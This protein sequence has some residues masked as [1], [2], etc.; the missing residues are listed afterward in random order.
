MFTKSFNPLA[1]LVSPFFFAL[2]VISLGIP[3]ATAQSPVIIFTNSFDS[4]TGTTP[5][6]F[7][8][9]AAN[10]SHTYVSGEGVGGSVGVRISGDFKPPGNGYGGVAYQYQNGA[11]TGNTNTD[12]HNYT[13]SFDAKPSRT[14]GGLQIVLQTWSGNGYGGIG[15]LTSSSL[16]DVILGDSNVF[17]HCS[18]NLGV[19]LGA[20]A[21][22]TAHTWQ[23]AFVMDEAPFGGPGTGDQLVI[24]NVSVTMGGPTWN[25]TNSLNTARVYQNNA[26]LLPDGTVL[27][28]G[29]YSS[30][31]PTTSAELYIP[32]TG[33]WQPTGPLH[34]ARYLHTSTLLKNGMVLAAGAFN[35]PSYFGVTELYDPQ[36]RIWTDTGALNAPRFFHT[37]TLLANGKVL[38]A[39]GLDPHGEPLSSSEIYDPAT[40]RWTFTTSLTTNRYGHTATLLPN[41]KVLAVG[42]QYNPPLNTAELFDP[43]TEQWTATAP[44]S[45]PREFHTATLLLNGKVL[46][47]GSIG[48]D[49]VGANSNAEL[50]DPAHES[51]SLTGAMN[52][53]RQQHTATLLPNGTVLLVGGT[54]AA[55]DLAELYNPNTGTWSPTASLNT[56]RQYHTTTLLA[57][58]KVL[59][60]GGADPH[61]APLS[62]AE[63]YDPAILLGT[64]FNLVNFT[65]LPNGTVQ[66][67]FTNT[68]GASFN[69]F[70][71]PDLTLP[72]ANW[73]VVGSITEISSGHY[74]FT[75]PDATNHAQNFY[76]VRTP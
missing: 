71:T 47:T 20:G 56:A 14:G 24:D 28:A 63:I 36:A 38:V 59:V 46:V 62:S 7:Y 25:P 22:V 30:G 15:P 31:L 44:M 49:G 3:H 57:N 70:G 61:Y 67:T 23:I 58:G 17:T 51:W 60:A 29:G 72:F 2:A 50:Y 6:Y 76:R 43:Q 68:S 74:L 37:A 18:L 41:G 12:P 52:A 55:F 53:P 73:P 19:K 45:I 5:G 75:D 35:L 40:G 4:L 8:G 32:T 39:G 69:A 26:T 11:V 66:F 33:T 16:T 48:L 13:L 54:P 21:D 64:P 9:D 34:Y 42:G 27:I 1:V 65:K 10:V